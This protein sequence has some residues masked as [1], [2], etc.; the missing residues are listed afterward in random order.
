MVAVVGAAGL[1]TRVGVAEVSDA[2]KVVVEA[3][4]AARR[5]TKAAAAA[6]AERVGV[7]GTPRDTCR[8]KS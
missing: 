3:R 2:A 6:A 4:E 5:G 7:N 8:R 1:A